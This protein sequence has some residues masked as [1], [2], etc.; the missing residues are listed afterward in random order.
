MAT[1]KPGSYADSK[2]LQVGDQI[3][4]V[5][6]EMVENQREFEGILSEVTKG[7]SIFLLVL[8]DGKKINLGLVREN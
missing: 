6:G 3:L 1:V 7:G 5:N 8:R 2:G 4:A